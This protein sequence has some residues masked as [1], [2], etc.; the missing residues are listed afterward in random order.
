M[1]R[2]SSGASRRARSRGRAP[3]ATGPGPR[4]RGETPV[5]SPS[6]YDRLNIPIKN[7]N[8]NRTSETSEILKELTPEYEEA[9]YNL[10]R[11]GY[12]FGDLVYLFDLDRYTLRNVFESLSLNIIVQKSSKS[13]SDE[14][15]RTER[16][17]LENTNSFDPILRSKPPLGQ[18]QND[19]NISRRSISDSTLDTETADSNFTPSNLSSAKNTW[20]LPSGPA[21]EKL[22]KHTN[23]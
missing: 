8:M 2:R 17:T 14:E 15:C 18:S 6:L 9:V 11:K 19:Y 4:S 20:P 13:T 23:R 7:T 22:L 21:N 12:T 10:L 16:T 5:A 1:R 3:K